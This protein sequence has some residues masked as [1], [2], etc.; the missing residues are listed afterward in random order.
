ML[1]KG[2]YL[3]GTDSVRT[4]PVKHICIPKSDK[5]N[6]ISVTTGKTIITVGNTMN[7][8]VI[9]LEIVNSQI[10]L[11]I[12]GKVHHL[13]NTLFEYQVEI[14]TDDSSVIQFIDDLLYDG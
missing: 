7:S 3:N 5:W 4:H 13:E 6:R 8:V 9:A 11:V 12:N 14:D 10:A 2:G 1:V